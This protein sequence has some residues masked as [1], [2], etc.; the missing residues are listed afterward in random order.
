MGKYDVIVIG[1]G[2]AGIESAMACKKMGIDVLLIT[3]DKEKIGYMSCNP[4]IGGV[5]KGQLV[6][7]IDALG[8]QM[9][10]ATD[11]TGIQF[12]ILNSS[13]GPAV[14]SSRAQVDRKKYN[15]YMKNL[16]IENVDII[17]GEVTDLIIENYSVKGVEVNCEKIIYSKSVIISTGT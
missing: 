6:K 10:K 1:G 15:E 5:G 3:F 8:G 16:I 14:W 11:K 9:A 17:E 2:H 12:R 7:E 4:A 13:K